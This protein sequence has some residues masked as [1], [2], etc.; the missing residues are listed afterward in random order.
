VTDGDWPALAV[1]L[2]AAGFAEV[3]VKLGA[4]GCLVS[5]PGSGPTPIPAIPA[6]VA[7]LTGAGDAFCGAY[8]AARASG[9][10][11]V[12]AARRAVVA[13]A[14]VIECSGAPAA[15]ALSP[16]EARRRLPARA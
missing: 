5:G 8:A 11:L 9:L 10:D 7:D 15:L 3:V 14:M 6:A 1:R 12:E 16:A 4:A 13:A 2:H